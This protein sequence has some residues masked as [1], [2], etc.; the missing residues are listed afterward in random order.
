[1]DAKNRLNVQFGAIFT[2]SLILELIIST[3]KIY[4]FLLLFTLLCCDD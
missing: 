1:M 2:L 3:N 4:Y